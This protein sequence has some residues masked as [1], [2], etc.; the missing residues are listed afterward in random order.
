[1]NPKL[2]TKTLDTILLSNKKCKNR[3]ILIGVCYENENIYSDFSWI[4]PFIGW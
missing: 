4:V 3:R 1:M 2:I